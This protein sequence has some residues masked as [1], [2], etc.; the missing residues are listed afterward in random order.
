MKFEMI[1]ENYNVKNLEESLEFYN[2]ALGLTEKRRKK[3]D[4]DSFIITYPELFIQ[5]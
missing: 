5:I 4:D 3:A 1:H 2:K